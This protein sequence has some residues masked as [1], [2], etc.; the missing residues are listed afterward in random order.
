VNPDFPV[1]H[2]IPD[3]F[4]IP[5]VRKVLSVLNQTTADLQAF[6]FG[7]ELG[8]VCVVVDLEVCPNRNDKGDNAFKNLE[9]NQERRDV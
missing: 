2:C 1:R 5:L 7:E 8:G 3:V 6:F 9:G 4:F